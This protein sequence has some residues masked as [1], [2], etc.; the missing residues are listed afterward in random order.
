MSKSVVKSAKFLVL[1]GVVGL[2]V[3]PASAKECDS[4][5]DAHLEQLGPTL[6]G[7]MEFAAAAVTV[8]AD[9]TEKQVYEASAGLALEK[10]MGEASSLYFNGVLKAFQSDAKDRVEGSGDE[11]EEEGGHGGGRRLSGSTPIRLGIRSAYYQ[12]ASGDFTSRLGF[13]GFKLNEGLLLDERGTGGYVDYRHGSWRLQGFGAQVNEEFA[14][15]G[16]NCAS[17]SLFDK[18]SKEGGIEMVSEDF[19][20]LSLNLDLGRAGGGAVGA[21][22]E[23]EFVAVDKNA[24]SAK[25][26]TFGLA[27][28]TENVN[29]EEKTRHYVDLHHTWSIL[30]VDY[31]MEAAV[32]YADAD[33]TFGGIARVARPTDMGDLGVLSPFAGYTAYAPI[34][35]STPFAAPN[36]NM[37]LGERMQYITMD[38]RVV[39]GGARL[40]TG[41]SW[42]WEL[43]HYRKESGDKSNETDVAATWRAAERTK[44]KLV[45]AQIHQ[46][47]KEPNDY[48]QV[49][50]ELRHVM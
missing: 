8:D 30:S 2:S 29:N 12:Y 34:K 32:Q 46:T 47:S 36:S 1:A 33:Q 43:S 48:H 6:R 22:G 31:A 14:R 41:P 10:K 17:K 42:L 16:R 50:L 3:G 11:E 44:W 40:A 20:G 49:A 23:D 37:F 26:P 24:I 19:A 25:S 18:K 35:G 7:N 45:Y 15:E 39:F 13:M 4:E 28:F 27:Y 9:G 5:L 21:T 38:N